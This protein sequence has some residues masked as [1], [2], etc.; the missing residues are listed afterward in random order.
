MCKLLPQRVH[1]LATSLKIRL[2]VLQK[3]FWDALNEVEKVLNEDTASLNVSTKISKSVMDEFYKTLSSC[4]DAVDEVNFF[5]SF[6][7]FFQV[8]TNF[9]KL[10]L[11][12][13]NYTIFRFKS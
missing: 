13:L 5:G 2:F 10:K 8:I 6:A 11:G 3:R 7:I 1:V 4:N 12:V 9:I